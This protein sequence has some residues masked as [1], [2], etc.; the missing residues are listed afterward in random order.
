M[1]QGAPRL[2]A[3]ELICDA[4]HRPGFA[5]VRVPEGAL[6][7]PSEVY[8]LWKPFFHKTPRSALI[9]PLALALLAG[10]PG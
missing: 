6:P 1:E 9:P 7:K 4:Y 5:L 3:H 8:A 10:G 2:P